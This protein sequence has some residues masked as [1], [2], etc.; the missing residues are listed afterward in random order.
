[1]LGQQ[2]INGLALGGVYAL[3]AAS[4]TLV[5]GVFGILNL[6]HGAIFTWGSLFGLYL[7]DQAGLPFV[8][9][10]LGGMLG[11][12][13]LS[14]VINRVVFEPLASRRS[15]N[16]LA[17]VLASLG[18]AQI[19]E[20]G[21][22]TVTDTKVQ[23]YPDG[24]LP[25]SSL[26]VLGVRITATDLVMFAAALVLMALLFLYLYRTNAGIRAR[27]TAESRDVSMLVGITPA[28]VS[29]EIFF[30]S[31]AV[32]GAAGVLIGA[33][34]DSVQFLMGSPYLLIGIVV[35]VV[36][37]LG[38]IQGALVAGLALGIVNSL[39]VGY[40]AAGWYDV[41]VWSLLLAVVLV[42]PSGLFSQVGAEVR[43][44]RR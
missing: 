2:L 8:V 13:L 31:G 5:F 39:S 44:V 20:R 32:A 36:G 42:R 29:S 6:A 40:L 37:G 3:F 1:V 17:F 25:S 4:L 14:V 34:F 9:A 19:L 27:A 22:Q 38:S 24:V 35:I 7:S 16:D 23:R 15:A 21:A 12:G 43:A 26:D 33:A 41:I 11:A 28:R 30:V 10:L 18:L